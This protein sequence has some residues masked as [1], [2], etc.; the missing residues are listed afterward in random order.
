MLRPMEQAFE[1]M[2]ATERIRYVQ[3]LWDR[4]AENPGDV[5]VSDPMKAELDLRLADHRSNPDEV[6]AWET[7]KAQSRSA[8]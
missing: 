5:P 2:S 3:A 4:I 8:K 7:V 1:T 6:V